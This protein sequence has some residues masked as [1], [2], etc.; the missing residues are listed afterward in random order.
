MQRIVQLPSA[1]RA[2][3]LTIINDAAHV[4]KEVIPRDRWKEPYMSIEELAEEIEA[5]VQFYGLVQEGTVL[6]VA[7][8]Q[9]CD[10]V[11][12]IR[13][14]Y[15]STR[16]QRRGIGS[17]LLQHIIRLTQTPEVLVGTWE[18]ATWAIRFYEQRGFELVS[19]E[20]KDRL[21]QRYWNI[22]QRQIETSVVLKRDARREQTV[23][24]ISK[25]R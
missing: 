4:Y 3:I 16:F 8:I 9:H 2:T 13:H 25:W 14:C 7:G 19:R 18:A 10:G 6:G 23:S 11:D 20:E 12:L 21:L 17:T 15:V 1:E 22:P 5:G 24:K